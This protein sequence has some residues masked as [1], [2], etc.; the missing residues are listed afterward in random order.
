MIE[1]LNSDY[2]TA[3][4]ARGIKRRKVIFTYGLR[5]ALIPLISLLGLSIPLLFSG[6]VIIEVVFSLPGMGRVMVNAVL[7]RD[8]PIILAASTLA[9]ISVTIGNMLADIAYAVAD[10]RIRFKENYN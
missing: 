5:N 9:F 3:A 8:Y 10:P 6:A 1:S 4:K 7:S 2:I